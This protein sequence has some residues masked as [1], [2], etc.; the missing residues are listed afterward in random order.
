L[1][2]SS[3]GGKTRLVKI[4]L[5]LVIVG[6]IVFGLVFWNSMGPARGMASNIHRGMSVFDV[7]E[8]GSGWISCSIHAM[9]SKNPKSQMPYIEITS[10][11][12]ASVNTNSS[13]FPEDKPARRWTS[14]RQFS[15]DL[16]RRIRASGT[17]WQAKFVFTGVMNRSD[18]I[19]TF[20]ADATVTDISMLHLELAAPN[21]DPI[22]H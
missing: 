22:P 9:P 19:V 21:T 1:L 4:S 18:F 8:S 10:P 20:G 2:T 5:F 13:T 6:L 12:S 15:A 14:R 17:P 11:A 16:E 3:I 7:M